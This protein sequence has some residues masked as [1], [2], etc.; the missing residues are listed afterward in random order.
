MSTDVFRGQSALQFAA[1][2]LVKNRPGRIYKLHV[3]AAVTGSITVYDNTAASGQIVYV[4]PAGPVIGQ[5]FELDI[6][7]R[8]GIYL[9][10]TSGTVTVVFT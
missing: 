4:S 1:S 9:S 5:S 6:P 7:C 2:S 3:Q 10:F 8:T